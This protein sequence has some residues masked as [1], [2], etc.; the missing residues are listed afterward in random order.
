M[1]D[2]LM[3]V[4]NRAPLALVQGRGAWVY[5]EDGATYLDCVGGVATNALGHAHP[6]LVSA[7]TEQAHR[8]W[9]VSNIF[10]IPGQD[11]LAERLVAASFADRVFFANTGSEAVECA[12]KTARRYHAANGQPER[13]DIIGFEGS[14][15]GRTYAAVN[16]SGNAAY[17]EG[18]GPRL[19]GYVQLNVRDAAGIEAAIAASAAAAVIVEPVQG[20]GGAKALSGEF[21][22]R[23]RALCTMRC[24]AA[25]GERASSSPTSGS[26]T[27]LRTS[28]PWP[29][30][31]ARAFPSPR[32]W[33]PKKPPR[34]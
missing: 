32:A 15:H 25:W 20:E 33:P 5:A 27:P 22:Q 4:Y 31:W 1:S 14:F 18:F 11:A 6:A 24:R 12:L 8:L 19:P 34:A 16:A 7:L 13:I 30:R 2:P 10:Q 28:W 23:L 17:L 3:N 29:R 21:L 26:R 9:H